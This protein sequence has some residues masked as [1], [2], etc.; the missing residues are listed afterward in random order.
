MC[1]A[2]EAERSLICSIES[3]ATINGFFA[4]MDGKLRHENPHIDNPFHTYERDAWNH[5][6]ECFYN[7]KYGPEHKKLLP[8]AIESKFNYDERIIVREYFQRTG[9]LKAGWRKRIE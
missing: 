7:D 4:A 6:W 9:K 5:G 1:Q 8:W 3:R 2:Y